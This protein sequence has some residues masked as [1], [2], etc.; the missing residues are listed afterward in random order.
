MVLGLVPGEAETLVIRR[1]ATGR[2]WSVF[3]TPSVS[4]TEYSI[5]FKFKFN[6]NFCPVRGTGFVPPVGLAG[7]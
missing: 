6:I 1:E 3:G 2:R 7:L 5:S 4:E